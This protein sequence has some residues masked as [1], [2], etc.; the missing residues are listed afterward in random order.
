MMILI[1]AVGNL[2]EIAE[3]IFGHVLHGWFPPARLYLPTEVGL[4]Y[5]HHEVAQRTR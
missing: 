4:D 5:P 3:F 1:V 2:E